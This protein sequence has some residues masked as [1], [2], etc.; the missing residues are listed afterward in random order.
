MICLKDPNRETVDLIVSSGI[1]LLVDGSLDTRTEAKTIF[2]PC[3]GHTKFESV[4]LKGIIEKKCKKEKNMEQ[5]SQ[6]NKTL[7]VLS[8]QE[9]NK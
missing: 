6:I 1:L 4:I 5:F 8:K 7:K 3:V 9:Q 2:S